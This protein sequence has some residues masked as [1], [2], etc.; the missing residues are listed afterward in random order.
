MIKIENL[1]KNYGEKQVIHNINLEIKKGELCGFIG[2]NGAGKTTIMKILTCL[3]KPGSG[4]VYIKNFS[5]IDSPIDVKRHIGYL[6]ENSSLYEDMT[7]NQ[8]LEFFS[9][10][11]GMNKKI[12]KKRV[13]ELL[14]DL[15]LNERADENI[16]SLSN[17]MKRKVAIIRAI[18][19]DPEVLIFDEP[20]VNLDPITS[21]SVRK[22]MK[23][24]QRKGKT[25]FFSTHNL[26]EVESICERIV[27][28]NKGKIILDGTIDELKDKFG[29]HVL[30][31]FKKD[32][33]I[34]SVR[35]DK[36]SVAKCIEQLSDGGEVISI[37]RE[38]DF[39]DIFEKLVEDGG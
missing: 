37:N 12:S 24:L 8:Y 17:G 30:V 15:G 26:Y 33:K 36:K 20:T 13:L 7:I 2:P 25:I 19:H 27:M 3:L 16:S 35:I 4:N 11:Y 9:E 10:I 38:F 21:S 29:E 34:Q 31:K 1:N 14:N 22:F 28:I 32:N 18:L 23:E 39:E 5:V 6:P